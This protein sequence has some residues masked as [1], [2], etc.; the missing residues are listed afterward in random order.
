MMILCLC[1]TPALACHSA[2][3]PIFP[4]SVVSNDLD[5]IHD[6]DPAPGAC[7]DYEGTSRAEMPDKRHDDLLADNVHVFQA[8]FADGTDV[9]IW[10]HPDVG[11]QLDA[12][13][14]A[15][16]VMQ[17]VAKLPRP[18]RELLGHVVIHKGDET[19]FSE[20]EGR[21]FVLYSDNIESRISTDDL[22]E[23]V[24]HESV[25][26]TLDVP[27]AS[28]A[29]WIAAQMAD[30]NFVTEYAAENP[31]GEDMAESAL[32][33]WAILKHPGRLPASVEDSVRTLIPNRLTFFEGLFSD[34]GNPTGLEND[35]PC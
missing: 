23:T 11:T 26:A 21:F 15:E 4:N 22:E 31:E 34:W 33:A 1:I 28:S 5:F 27:H 6:D 30:A 12:E 14:M 13:G 32:F 35:A 29:D 20:D 24:F 19:A 7:L 3:E 16:P 18:L 17:A 2:A 25:H 10:V 8:S 9:G